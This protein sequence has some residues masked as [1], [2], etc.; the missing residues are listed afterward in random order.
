MGA[1]KLY[2]C[3]CGYEKQIMAGAGKSSQNFGIISRS[4]PKEI[5]EEFSREEL[6]GNVTDFGMV[7]SIISCPNCKSLDAVTDF[8]YTLTESEVRYVSPCPGCGEECQPLENT[9]TIFC[10]KCNSKMSC[11]VVGL[12]D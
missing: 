2:K 11:Y 6:S 7:R 4:V 5:F 1:C 9:E 3:R 12:W 10:P 8:W